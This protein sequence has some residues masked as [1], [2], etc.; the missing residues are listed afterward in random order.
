MLL[1]QN[2][3]LVV[4]VIHSDMYQG[5]SACHSERKAFGLSFRHIE[6]QITSYECSKCRRIQ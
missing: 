5:D 4:L 6:M 1:K 2:A 3:Y